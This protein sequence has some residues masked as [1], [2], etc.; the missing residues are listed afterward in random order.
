MSTLV[1][2]KRLDDP[3]GSW[4]HPLK[5]WME[6][7]G[8]RKRQFS[9]S[10]NT[11]PAMIDMP[12]AKETASAAKAVVALPAATTG[13]PASVSPASSASTKIVLKA[14]SN[15]SAKRKELDKAVAIYNYSYASAQSLIDAFAEAKAK[16]GGKRGVLTDQEQDILRADLVMAC[17]GID[18]SIK[19]AIRDCFEILFQ[20]NQEAHKLFQRFIQKRLG[21]DADGDTSLAGTKFL[22]LI[23]AEA[24]PRERL[25]EEYIKEL[26]GDSLQSFDQLMKTSA[27]LGLEIQKQLNAKKD[28]LSKIFIARYQ[29]IHELD[30]NLESRGR[31]RRVRGQV[32]LIN[33]VDL[34]LETM[35]IFINRIDRLLVS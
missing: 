31:K 35:E 13:A 33:D 2:G 8:P 4:N 26:T 10:R 18:S 14:K 29:I 20:K 23:L 30:I 15:L 16:R 27:A 5:S 11:D 24:S 25:I 19:Q 9:Y 28:S 6:A 34:V 7:R 1:A 21:G 3:P 32:R 22:A 17:A 12:A